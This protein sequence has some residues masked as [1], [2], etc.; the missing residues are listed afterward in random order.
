VLLNVEVVVG[1][2]EAEPAVGLME[3]WA[4]GLWEEETVL[5]ELDEREE[6]KMLPLGVAEGLPL[7]QWV[8][9]PE[10]MEGVVVGDN[11]AEPPVGLPE[12]LVPG[13]SEWV[14]VLEELMETV[15]LGDEEEVGQPERMVLG[16]REK[17]A[18]LVEL[19]E[20][21]MLGDGEGETV[22]QV[23]KALIL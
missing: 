13:L 1:D 19:M 9:L 23:L 4:V 10:R 17:V 18:T 15:T 11:V 3:R 5:V 20:I 14:I 16:L 6:K 2:E 12:R 22:G 7:V 21:V 8:E